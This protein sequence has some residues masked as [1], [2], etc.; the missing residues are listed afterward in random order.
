M[1]VN[2]RMTFLACT[3]V[4]LVIMMVLA[5]RP[6]QQATVSDSTTLPS[7]SVVVPSVAS[8]EGFDIEPYLRLTGT[9]TSPVYVSG[10][11]RLEDG[12]GLAGVTITFAYSN[13]RLDPVATTDADG[14]YCYS[15]NTLGHQ[16]TIT[17]APEKSGYTFSPKRYSYIS[18]TWGSPTTIDFVAR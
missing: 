11:V 14:F 17:I 6:T 7:A 1:K 5:T 3:V 15:T 9:P 16:E 8:T 4:F 12:T 10:H 13:Y 18:S 2:T